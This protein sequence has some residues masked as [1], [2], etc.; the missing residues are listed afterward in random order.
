MADDVM[1]LMDTLGLAQAHLFGKSMG[2]MIA[3]LMAINHSDKLLSLVSVM[4]TSSRPGLPGPSNATK[5]SLMSSPGDAADEI[6]M[7]TALGL[8]VCGSPGYPEPLGRRLKIAKT[9]HERDYSPNGVARQMAAVINDGD[10][11]E[12]LREVSIPTTVMHGVDDPLIP[13]ACGQDTANCISDSRMV[14][15]PGMGHNL[16]EELV[17]DLLQIIADHI[18]RI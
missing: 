6:I 17:P 2:G 14:S 10:R 5:E 7:D 9:R 3:Q 1:G 16:P 11:S 4:S 12:R 13:I 15:V 8:E 18:H